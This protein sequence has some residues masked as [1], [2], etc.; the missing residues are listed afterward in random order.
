MIELKNVTKKY[1]DFYALRDVSFTIEDG[2]IVGF[3]GRNGAGKTT[4]MNIIT[5]FIEPNSGDILIEGEDICMHPKKAKKYIGYMPEGTP[6]YSDM[7]V[8]EFISYMA[9]LKLVNKKDKKRLVDEAIEKTG[10]TNVQNNLT[11]NLSRGYKQRTSFAG[12]IVSNPKILILDEP[13]VGLDPKQV[14]E[15]R[16]LIKD[17]GK[18][19]TVFISSHILFEISQICSKVIIIDK[20]EIVRID[21]PENL[22]KETTTVPKVHVTIEKTDKDFEKL[23]KSIKGVNEIVKAQ[24]ENNE[25]IYDISY[26]SKVDLRKDLFE[27]CSKENIVVLEMKKDE[28]S[29]EDAYI[30]LI[31]N[32]KEYSQTEIRKMEYDK[33]IEELREENRIKKE[34]KEKKKQAKR[35][36]KLRKKAQKEG[37]DK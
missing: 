3:L 11:R 18:E 16:E 8:R 24:E 7:T 5:G 14:V 21:T 19:H 35:E 20:G 22:E 4:T 27:L 13:T 23:V 34:E 10:L 28:G 33:E 15:I 36:E 32:R 25:T 9:D 6:L 37:G 17:Y 26:D 30:K 1:G 31:E 2:G 29:L 12:A